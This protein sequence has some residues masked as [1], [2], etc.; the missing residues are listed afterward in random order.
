MQF[1]QQNAIASLCLAQNI[2]KKAKMQAMV[3]PISKKI[4][5]DAGNGT[6]FQKNYGLR[7][8]WHD[9]CRQQS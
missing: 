3:L 6:N 9:A 8:A 2:G 1:G 5:Q 4:T 7:Q